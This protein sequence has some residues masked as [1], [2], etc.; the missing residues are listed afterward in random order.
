VIELAALGTCA[1]LA[2]VPYMGVVAMVPRN[3]RSLA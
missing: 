1:A 2:A 3:T